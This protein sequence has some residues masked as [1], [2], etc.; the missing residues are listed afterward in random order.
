MVDL[1]VCVSSLLKE[2]LAWATDKR[3]WVISNIMLF[4]SSYSAKE[5]KETKE[6]SRFCILINMYRVMI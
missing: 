4:K 6:Y 3:L 1:D 2:E 5:L